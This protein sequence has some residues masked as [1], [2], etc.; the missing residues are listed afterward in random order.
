MESERH[1]EELVKGIS[2]QLGLILKKSEQAV[3]I[4]LDDTH[5][6]CNEKFASLLG[7]KSA[8]EWADTEAPLDDVDEASQQA[9]ISAYE[10][11]TDKL[12]A[13]SLD[14]V[15]KNVKTNSRIK[16]KLIV[17]PVVYQGHVF[18]IH[19]LSKV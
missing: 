10:K 7:Y 1:H 14:I 4:Y 12:A 6:V 11:A 18:A 15:V 16:T 19:F 8:K 3:Y 13:S 17:A 2:E 5:K 9:V